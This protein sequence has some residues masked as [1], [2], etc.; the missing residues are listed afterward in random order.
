MPGYVL[1]VRSNVKK[2]ELCV[3]ENV[4]G[5]HCLPPAQKNARATKLGRCCSIMRSDCHLIGDAKKFFRP[6]GFSG[7]QA[8]YRLFEALVIDYS[9]ISV[10]ALE[11]KPH[12]RT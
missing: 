3:G 5:H 1:Y 11:G 7:R 2:H 6:I 10:V 8:V 9:S 4:S 12:S